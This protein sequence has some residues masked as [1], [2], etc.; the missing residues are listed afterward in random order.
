MADQQVLSVFAQIY[1]GL[2]IGATSCKSREKR[3]RS[4]SSR[5]GNGIRWDPWTLWQH[6][7]RLKHFLFD[8][9]PESSLAL[10]SDRSVGS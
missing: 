8:C 10:S 1:I 4:S 5:Y 3:I 9:Q 6:Q 2:D 7:A